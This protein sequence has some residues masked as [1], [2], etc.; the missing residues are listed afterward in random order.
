MLRRSLVGAGA[1]AALL[2]VLVLGAA[3]AGAET[4][5]IRAIDTTEFPEVE[6]EA[7]LT[8]EAPRL[9]DV[10]LRENGSL[11]HDLEVVPIGDTA[12][13]VGVVL[14]IDVSGSMNQGGALGRAR[15]A[16]KE[17]V[18]NRLENDSIALV[19]FGSE[20]RVVVNFTK[21]ADLLRT[22]IDDLAAQGET[23]LYDGIRT[24]V[25]LFNDRPDLQPNV[26]VLTDGKDTVSDAS[27]GE[28]Q[29]AAIDGKVAVFGVGIQTDEFEPGPLQSIA[30]AS[31]ADLFL[32]SDAGA[33]SSVYEQ[34]QSSLQNQLRISY[35]SEAETPSIEVVLS[36]GGQQDTATAALGSRSAGRNVSPKVVTADDGFL[37]GEAGKVLGLVLALVAFVMVAIAVLMLFVSDDSRLDKRLSAYTDGG[38]GAE[39]ADDR[40]LPQIMQA[41]FVR[42]AVAATSRF[43]ERQGFLPRVEEALE[44][45]HLPLRAG[46]AM[47]AYAALVVVATIAGLLVLQSLFGGLI[48]LVLAALLPPAVVN[49]LAK[50]RRKKFMSQLPDTL[51]LLSGSLRAGYSLMQGVEAV[52]QEV[53]APM[54]EELRRIITETRLGRTLEDSLTDTAERMGSDDFAW[55]VMAIQ[56]QREVGG[57]LA[58]LLDTVADTMVQRERLRREVS[59]LTAEGRISAIVLGAL[60]VGMLLVLWAINPGYIE[61]LFEE[62]VGRMMLL[63]GGILAGA[64]FLWLRSIVDVEI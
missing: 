28:A 17:F 45:A 16:A 41:E 23:A 8:G 9:S 32:A 34:V 61:V 15:D 50:R 39:D 26:V 64:G 59:A 14:A 11:V 63:G 12:Q 58:E 57:N 24:S 35:T 42:Q 31:G 38:A 29:G 46:E 10:Q 19:A 18:A 51:Q 49:H 27:R 25:A 7:I 56:I 3:P 5:T 48:V 30:R 1:L 62:S 53:V 44:R 55:A 60:P 33:L 43:A 52:S 2:A 21:D 37:S 13:P 36:A 6:V 4:L 40:G 22:A 47:V 54:G 20:A